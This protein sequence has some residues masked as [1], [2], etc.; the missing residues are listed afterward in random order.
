MDITKILNSLSAQD[1][2][3]L[4]TALIVELQLSKQFLEKKLEIN[5]EQ[6]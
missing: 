3:A 1:K 4:N 2:Y 5:E 6:L